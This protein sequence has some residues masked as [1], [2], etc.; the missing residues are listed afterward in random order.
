[1][2]TFFELFGVDWNDTTWRSYAACIGAWIIMEVP[3][4]IWLIVKKIKDKKKS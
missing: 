3:L 2:P 4:G 1:M